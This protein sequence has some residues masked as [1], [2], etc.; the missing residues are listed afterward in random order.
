MTLFE[1][2]R[3]SGEVS[4]AELLAGEPARSGD[5]GLTVADLAGEIARGG[6]P[7]FRGLAVERA[8]RAV[9]GYLEEI[10]RVDVGRVEDRR[11][12]PGKVGRLL[13]KPRPQRRHAR[14]GDDARRGHRW[15]GRPLE[16]GDG[17]GSTSTCSN[18]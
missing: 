2:G 18:G 3:G 9:R 8:L 1:A 14:R 6:W 17:S 5:P 7:G 11:R 12:D 15:R 13:R 16:G 10:R 4:L